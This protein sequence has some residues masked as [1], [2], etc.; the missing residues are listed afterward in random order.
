MQLSTC[1]IFDKL[2]YVLTNWMVLRY[3]VPECKHKADNPSRVKNPQNLDFNDLKHTLHCYKKS[4]L[5][6]HIAY[7]TFLL[8]FRINI[9]YISQLTGLCNGEGVFL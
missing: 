3:F 7:Y 8:I 4:A 5:C 6:A 2:Q 1:V 9:N